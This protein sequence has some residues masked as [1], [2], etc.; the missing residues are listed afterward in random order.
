MLSRKWTTEMFKEY[1]KDNFGNEFK[2]VGEYSGNNVNIKMYHQ[3]CDK[4][5]Y[6]RPS[7]F[8]TRKRCPECNRNNK[9]RTT[10]EFKDI[11]KSLTGEDYEVLGKYVTVKDKIDML[12]RE[13]GNVYKV[14]PDD[15]IN[16]GTRCPKCFGNFG[17]STEE[18]EEVL[19]EMVGD[20]YTLIS[21]YRNR[22]TLITFRHND[23]GHIFEKSHEIFRRGHRCPKCGLEKRSGTNH[24]RYRA[25]L[26]EEERA[27]SR[28]LRRADIIKWRTRV[29]KRDNYTCKKCS[30]VGAKLNAHH[31]L[32]WSKNKDKRFD[33]DNGATLCVNCHKDFH[34]RYGYGGNDD[35]QFTRFILES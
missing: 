24:Y 1:V 22:D 17:W 7:N 8:K 20:E 13:C 16:G 10:E 6:V 26:T 21:E 11:V 15:F 29:F 18:Y 3:T 12:H 35:K 19:Y 5:F 2:V 31:I 14:T 23:C 32:C 34:K 28:E 4:E 33:V 30:K 25:D 27:E 9:K